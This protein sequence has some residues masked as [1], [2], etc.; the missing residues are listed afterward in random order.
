MRVSVKET[1]DSSISIVTI[2]SY[3]L[4]DS[5]C[6]FIMSIAIDASPGSGEVEL[7]LSVDRSIYI[8]LHILLQLVYNLI[9][10][11]IL[12]T[13]CFSSYNLKWSIWV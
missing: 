5:P 2:R 6:G 9:K 7:Y 10:F 11:I 3:K 12:S 4:P 8:Q 13:V 1:E